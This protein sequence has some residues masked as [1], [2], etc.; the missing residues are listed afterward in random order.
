MNEPELHSVVYVS[1]A[2]HPFST[3]QLQ[4][5]LEE[6]CARNHERSITG[7]LLYKD[8]CFI[9]A[10]EGRKADVLGL[11]SRIGR[12]PR[13][14]NIVVL[15]NG[16]IEERDFAEWNMGFKRLDDQEVHR[17]PGFAEMV[18]MM[19]KHGRCSM[20]TAFAIK[21]LRSFAED[22]GRPR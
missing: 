7:M 4:S 21:L 18:K 22:S 1:I 5:L 11:Y 6:S 17:Q 20:D 12:D 10:F 8:G 19:I 9:Q 13:H 2:V 15:F 16:P 14:R 3:E